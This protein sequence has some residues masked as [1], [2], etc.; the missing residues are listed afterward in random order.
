MS[1]VDPGAVYEL[2]R[3]AVMATVAGLSDEQFET[4]VPATPAWRV[5]DVLAHVVGLAADLNAQRFPD[6]HDVGGAAWALRQVASRSDTAIDDIL[7]EW[8]REAPTFEEGLRL[9]GYEEGSHFVADLHA[10][11]QDIR[12]AIGL[13]PDDDELTV[14][15]ALDHYLGF[16]D[17]MITAA[18]WGTLVVVAVV[19]EGVEERSLGGL[20]P[21]HARMQGSAFEVLR[22]CSARRSARQIRA[23][24]WQGDVDALLSLLQSGFTGGYALPEADLV[25]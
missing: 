10:H 25:E 12:G 11:H 15:V 8:S 13:P 9:F 5:R 1:S 14:G 6:A 2:T 20:G 4:V 18:G 3:L 16:L 23:L 24:D 22:C 17:Q 7:A 21:H 19:S